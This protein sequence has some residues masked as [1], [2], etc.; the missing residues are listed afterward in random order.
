MNSNVPV[1]VPGLDSGVVAI[2][3]GY[4]NMYALME[5]GSVRGWGNPM[6]FPSMERDTLTADGA[7]VPVTDI[8]S[9][10]TGLFV[11]NAH[12]CVT[13]DEGRIHCWGTN[14]AGQLGNGDE[15]LPQTTLIVSGF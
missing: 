14:D 11:G 7:P 6:S 2:G 4:F 13:T 12:A 5:D 15:V 10:V 8:P 3:A 9:G 1:T